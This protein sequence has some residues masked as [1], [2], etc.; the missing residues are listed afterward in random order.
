VEALGEQSSSG[1]QM[2]GSGQAISGRTMGSFSR[3]RSGLSSMPRMRAGRS[4]RSAGKQAS[5]KNGRPASFATPL[6]LCCLTTGWLSRRSA[7]LWATVHRTSPRRSIA[8]RSGRSSPLGPR[9][10]TRSSPT[11]SDLGEAGRYEPDPS[12]RT[13]SLAS[14]DMADCGFMPVD[15]RESNPSAC[16]MWPDAGR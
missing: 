6:S 1:R 15:S 4:G 7:A 9:R 12:M 5:P 3:Q 16:P 8:T 2:R 11:S 14:P 10:W 13:R